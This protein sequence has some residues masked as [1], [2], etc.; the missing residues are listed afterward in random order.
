MKKNIK[1]F[2]TKFW[3]GYEIK[4]PFEVMDAFFDFAHLDSYKEV[5]SETFL[6]I[7]KTEVCRIRYPGQVL[8]FRSAFSSFVKAC[9]LLQYKNRKWKVKESC[10][11][12]SKLDMASLTEQEYENPFTVFQKAFEQNTIDKFEFFLF[13]ISHLSLSPFTEEFDYDL[14]TPYIYLVKMLDASQLM[15]DRGIE[16]IKK[17]SLSTDI[18]EQ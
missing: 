10:A 6:Y 2:E 11:C 5:L 8:V 4:N 15:R 7:H 3:A 16:K 17:V 14:I 12:K 13:E 1:S 9:F 18:A